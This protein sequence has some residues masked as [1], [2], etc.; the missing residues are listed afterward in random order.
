MIRMADNNDFRE[1]AAQLR[2]Q[3]MNMGTVLG[4]YYIVKFCLFT[5]SMKSGAL[6]MLFIVVRRC[7]MYLFPA[8]TGREIK[9]GIV[10]KT[11]RSSSVLNIT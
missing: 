2:R 10:C 9:E 11:L 4:V 1:K 6:G 3:S 5:M 7:G 8:M